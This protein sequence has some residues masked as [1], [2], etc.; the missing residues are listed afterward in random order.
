MPRRCGIE[1]ETPGINSGGGP[2]GGSG[3]STNNLTINAIE[4]MLEDGGEAYLP[5]RVGDLPEASEVMGIR[6]T[7]PG[8]RGVNRL[9]TSGGKRPRRR[10]DRREKNKLGG[11]ARS[12]D[13]KR[14]AQSSDCRSTTG[15]SVFGDDEGDRHGNEGGVSSL[16]RR[17]R[18]E[19]SSAERFLHPWQRMLEAQK[20]E[21]GRADEDDFMMQKE[22]QQRRR[23]ARRAAVASVDCRRAGRR[24]AVRLG[25]HQRRRPHRHGGRDETLL[26]DNSNGR[27]KNIA[28]EGK[29]GA[30]NGG[31]DSGGLERA[32]GSCSYDGRE[33]CLDQ[34]R[35]TLGWARKTFGALVRRLQDRGVI[36]LETTAVGDKKNGQNG[37]NLLAQ[38]V[39]GIRSQLAAFDNTC[40]I[41]GAE[42]ARSTT[43]ASTTSL[44]SQCDAACDSF[45]SDFCRLIDELTAEGKTEFR[46]PPSSSLGEESSLPAASFDDKAGGGHSQSDLPH[47]GSVVS[48]LPDSTARATK[49]SV[50]NSGFCPSCS[51]LPVAR[52]CLDCEGGGA[53]RDRCSGCFV[54]D[55]RDPGRRNHRFLRVSGVGG[56]TGSASTNPEH[57][58]YGGGPGATADK[59][60]AIGIA[61]RVDPVASSSSSSSC[62]ARCSMCGDLAA[63][64]R[65]RDCRVDTCAACHFLAHR[66]PSRQ[67][68][69]TEFVGETA[70]AMQEALHQQRQ[71]GTSRRISGGEIYHGD[72]G[73]TAAGGVR[74][75]T[76]ENGE[77]DDA[78]D[79]GHEM[80]GSSKGGGV[81]GDDAA[82]SL[83]QVR[84]TVDGPVVRP[85]SSA[86][87][88]LQLT[89]SRGGG[90]PAVARDAVAEEEH[91][92]AEKDTG[93]GG[94]KINRNES[95]KD[96]KDEADYH[97]EGGGKEEAEEEDG[98]KELDEDENAGGVSSTD[99]DTDDEG[100]VRE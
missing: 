72:E 17:R 48:G 88:R 86:Q 76:L 65:C 1:G 20:R 12:G 34:L 43:A 22:R 91:S 77:D 35:D 25:R 84:G 69:V 4:A 78:A 38:V 73:S 81:F 71:L 27:R 85:V 30:F 6:A 99:E 57:A 49:T 95:V 54:R 75:P 44:Q 96:N 37:G 10:S 47:E 55:H 61:S 56:G 21:A 59:T 51:V 67:A 60:T 13:D 24:V 11:G 15:N 80:G 89:P 31:D 83:A 90:D 53:D 70:V 94:E 7:S 39:T 40:A 16:H 63:A 36:A 62:A 93:S 2:Y 46:E 74:Q 82:Q 8:E 52:R 97:K 29:F 50:S 41:F 3:G 68:H 98:L 42:V 26:L 33:G 58:P 23:D 79:D 5:E 66:T 14:R 9:S 18:V 32:S 28:P 45:E 64:R 92:E 100:M 87:S 19:R